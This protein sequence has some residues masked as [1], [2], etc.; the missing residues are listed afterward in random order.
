M[1]MDKH[2]QNT[3]NKSSHKHQKTTRPPNASRKTNPAGTE[4]LKVISQIDPEA[5]PSLREIAGFLLLIGKDEA[6]N[7]LAHLPDDMIEKISLEI[8]Q[9]NTLSSEES[10]NIIERFHIAARKET[11]R[12]QGGQEFARELLEKSLGREKAV[13]I[14]GRTNLPPVNQLNFLNVLEPAQ[15][16]NLLA[17]EPPRVIGIILS[18]LEPKL[19]ADFLKILPPDVKPQ[20]IHTMREPV[21][22]AAE[23]IKNIEETL[24]KKIRQLG[25]QQSETP[26]GP[27]VMAEILRNMDTDEEQNILSDLSR[28]VPEVQEQIK[29][30]LFTIEQVLNIQDLDLQRILEEMSDEDIALLMKGKDETIR[31]RFLDNLSRQRATAVSETYHFMGAVPK[32]EVN[33]IT[34]KFI[35]TLEELK[36]K[37]A[38]VIFRENDKIIQ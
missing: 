7:V 30:H 31:R 38:L 26:D 12:L 24:K 10:R 8:S 13:S 16:Q 28:T 3:Y 2:L 33:E 36:D 21:K 32:K 14:L 27:Q 18:R 25:T 29:E 9:I 17:H 6:A 15:L 35:A 34:R 11:E 5:R 20:I 23:T 22:I 37:G 1:K 4:F 19:A